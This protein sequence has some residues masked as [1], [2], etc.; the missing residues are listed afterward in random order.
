M[1][2]SRQ[3]RFKYSKL[4]NPIPEVSAIVEEKG[5]PT[6]MPEKSEFVQIFISLPELGHLYGVYGAAMQISMN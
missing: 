2:R 5:E 1:S 4:T 3:G 6:G